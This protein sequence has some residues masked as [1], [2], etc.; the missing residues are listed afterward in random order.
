MEIFDPE[1]LTGTNVNFLERSDGF[2]RTEQYATHE[3]PKMQFDPDSFLPKSLTKLM[4]Y[5][6]WDVDLFYKLTIPFIALLAVL[7]P[8][9]FCLSFSRQTPTYL[10][11]ALSL[12][13]LIAYFITINAALILGESNTLPAA[14]TMLTPL[15][16]TFFFLSYHYKKMC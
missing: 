5:A 15:A 16:L 12:F 11:Y 2:H 14:P 1:H 6:K 3:F 7:G 9:P 13:S 10:L 8:L 4:R